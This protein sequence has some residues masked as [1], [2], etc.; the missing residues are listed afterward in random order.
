VPKRT[1]ASDPLAGLAINMAGCWYR[2]TLGARPGGQWD[3]AKKRLLEWA[4]R[5]G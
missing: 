3:E 2:C 1:G 4:E 5:V